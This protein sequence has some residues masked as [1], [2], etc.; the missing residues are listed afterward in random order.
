MDI[1]VK[2]LRGP[3]GLKATLVA[4]F[5]SV[6]I[7]TGRQEGGGMIV[8]SLK[9]ALSRVSAFSLTADITGEPGNYD[10]KVSSDLDRVFKDAVGRIVQEQSTR[11][12]KELKA[13]VQAKTGEKLKD[14]KASLGGLNSLGGNIDGVQNQLNALLQEATQKSGGKA[15]LPF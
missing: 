5:K 3:A 9:N 6:R 11:L 14:L 12:E 10:V 2:G 7:N 13:A 4:T 8:A 1:E 15:R